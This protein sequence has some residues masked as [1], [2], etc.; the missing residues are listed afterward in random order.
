MLRHEGIDRALDFYDRYDRSAFSAY[1]ATNYAVLLALTSDRR[2]EARRIWEEKLRPG[3]LI[4]PLL[5]GDEEVAKK[6][7][8]RGAGSDR[9]HDFLLGEIDE[10]EYLQSQGA[11]G[12]MGAH[13]NIG[14]KSLSKRDLANAGKHFQ[15]AV[16]AGF[17]AKA[18]SDWAAA[19]LA[20]M[21][22]DP[23]W[24]QHISQEPAVVD[25]ATAR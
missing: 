8:V 19:F 2:E 4:V 12:R 14:L 22:R 21:K 11:S 15:L 16:D 9:L 7:R 17:Y 24:P 13:Y 23:S 18:P 3:G 6:A 1:E 20:Q 25:S 10:S 5:L